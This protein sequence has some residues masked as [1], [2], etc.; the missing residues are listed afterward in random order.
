MPLKQARPYTGSREQVITEEDFLL[1]LEEA[2]AG[3]LSLRGWLKDDEAPE[4][5]RRFVSR[6]LREVH[7]VRTVLN[8]HDAQE[9]RTFS[10]FMELVA[11]VRGFGTIVY[12]LRHLRQRFHRSQLGATEPEAEAFLARMTEGLASCRG[13]LRRLYAALL[14]ECEHLGI[15]FPDA[16][17]P[18][19][20]EEAGDEVRRHLPHNIDEE[21]LTQDGEKVAQVASSFIRAAEWYLGMVP[22]ELETFP[23]LR[24][25]VLGKLDEEEA[26]R[27]E[28]FVHA[29]QSKYDT[30][31]QFTHFEANDP[32][33]KRLRSIISLTLH[34]F[35]VTTHLVHF[36][37][38]H[39]NDIRSVDAKERI[40]RIVDKH[41]VL[42][43]AV[44]FAFRSAEWFI[45]EGKQISEA[46]IPAHTSI[47][48]VSFDIPPGVK[49][50][51]RPA[52]LIARIVVHYGTP[53]KMRVETEWCDAASITEVI[54][55]AGKHLD[56]TNVTFQGDQR[57][58]SDLGTLFEIGLYDE[59]HEELLKRLPYLYAGP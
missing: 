46:L 27:I 31:I 30:Y 42:D 58:L 56:A 51:I 20:V 15:A 47:R 1:L 26:R 38:R 37:E 52:A 2:A 36:Y 59:N 6:L 48:R 14:D 18:D 19:R 33:L 40:A 43:L 3:L 39:E 4:W 13:T 50:H 49:L 35:E 25:F 29:L 22:Q 9:N 16:A 45:R 41:D 23:E 21:D 17:S 12:I 24:E 11:G 10:Y 54:F 44:N 5:G 8:D 7:T 57:P 28:S 34:L 55:A 53:V 32:D